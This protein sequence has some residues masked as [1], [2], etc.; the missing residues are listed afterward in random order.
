[1]GAFAVEIQVCADSISAFILVFMA[2]F[3]LIMLICS[4]RVNVVLV[5][6]LLGVFLGFVLVGA[7]LF[8]EDESIR[9]LTA[10]LEMEASGNSAAAPA[11]LE[12]G[13]NRLNLALRL[14]TVSEMMSF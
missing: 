11:M 14:V 13:D 2:V 5:V 10:A 3:T 9:M 7:A 6:L 12:A 4:V 1:M 8:I